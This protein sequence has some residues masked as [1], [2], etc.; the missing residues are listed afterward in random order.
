[1]TSLVLNN[2][3]LAFIALANCFQ[4]YVL[5][6]TGNFNSKRF[7]QEESS[8]DRGVYIC[9]KGCRLGCYNTYV[10]NHLEPHSA[11]VVID[12]EFFCQI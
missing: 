3:A 10:S 7:L 1:M 11:N 4:S 8:L 2:R 12:E 6:Q 9:G 5:Y